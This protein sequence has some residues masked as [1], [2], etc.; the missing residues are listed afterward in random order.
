MTFMGFMSCVPAGITC[1][2]RGTF[3]GITGCGNACDISCVSA[4]ICTGVIRWAVCTWLMGVAAAIICC[5]GTGFVAMAT[6]L[7][8]VNEP[9]VGT[10]TT[11]LVV[12]IAVEIDTGM[13]LFI[14]VC[15]VMTP[16]AG[17]AP[18][19][20]AM[21]SVMIDEHGPSE[22]QDGVTTDGRIWL[23]VSPVRT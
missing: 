3:A 13:N 19:D 6:M 23:T 5:C 22:A 1:V 9:A 4:D 7:P 10:E 8:V 2:W 12:V 11:L 20:S 15:G 16:V 18:V 14:V 17:L 21:G